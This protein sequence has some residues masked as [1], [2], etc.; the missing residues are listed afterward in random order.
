MGLMDGGSSLM[1]RD[2]GAAVLAGYTPEVM[3]S[4]VS[5][6]PPHLAASIFPWLLPHA[7]QAWSI[8]HILAERLL[9]TAGNVLQLMFSNRPPS[10][11]LMKSR[12]RVSHLF[13]QFLSMT[14]PGQRKLKCFT[15]EAVSDRL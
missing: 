5:P 12:N 7:D 11:I 15:G 14:S 10:P 13:R 2:L 4:S 8:Q 6:G 1:K 9:T 3:I